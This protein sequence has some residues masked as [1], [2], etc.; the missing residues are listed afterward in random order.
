M[1]AGSHSFMV[2][3][4]RCTVL[5]DGYFSYPA[6]WLFANVEPERVRQ[7]LSEHRLGPEEVLSPYTCL[8]IETGRHVVLADAGGGF[9]A[10]TTGA[11][12]ARLEM[13]GL[14]PKDVDTV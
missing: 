11:I 5:S 7:V 8:L 9:G 2:G 6:E 12:L 14:R 10:R 4:V 13:E 3:S 1:P